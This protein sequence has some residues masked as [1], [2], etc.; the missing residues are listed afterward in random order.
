MIRMTMAVIFCVVSVYSFIGIFTLFRI[1][2]RFKQY[3]ELERKAIIETLAMSM[4]IIL[5]VN[6]GQLILSFITPYDWAPFIFSGSSL[7]LIGNTPLH[8]DSFFFD[9]S[10]LGISYMVRRHHFGLIKVKNI[11]IPIIIILIFILMPLMLH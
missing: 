9:C 1:L 10:I 11:L 4:V 3:D 7:A 6:F 2:V 5:V 8:F